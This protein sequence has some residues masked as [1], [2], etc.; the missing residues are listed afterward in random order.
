M[1]QSLLRHFALPVWKFR[2]RR[3]QLLAR[4]LSLLPDFANDPTT[5]LALKIT[6]LTPSVRWQAVCQYHVTGETKLVHEY[7][8][9]MV[10]QDI[11]NA[12][13]CL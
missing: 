7:S 8:G 10:A 3:T 11:L 9:T 12:H 1:Y 2:Y 4:G 6:F 13:A 5:A